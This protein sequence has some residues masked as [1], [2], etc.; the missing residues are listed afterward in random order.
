M[1]ALVSARPLQPAQENLGC[2]RVTDRP[3]TQATL[4]LRVRR[5]LPCTAGRSAR[6]LNRRRVRPNGGGVVDLGAGR[7][8]PR[9]RAGAEPGEFTR[10][11]LT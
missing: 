11:L 5:G 4:D 1:N 7:H 9:A 10:A 6:R 2:A 8:V 3:L